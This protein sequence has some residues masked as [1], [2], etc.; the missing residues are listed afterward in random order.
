MAGMTARRPYDWAG[1]LWTWTALDPRSKLLITWLIGSR[2][3]ECAHRLM[4]DLRSR[5]TGR[6][7]LTTAGLRVCRCGRGRVRC[8]CRLRTDPE[9]VPRRRVARTGRH[10]RPT[11]LP[12]ARSANGS[13]ADQRRPGSEPGVDVARRAQEP[14]DAN[15]G[16]EIHEADETASASGR[17][18]MRPTRRSTV[19]TTTSAGCTEPCG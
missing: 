14:D 18:T 12:A 8:G 10:A 2:S 11:V 1:D 19:C 6:V 9:D 16:A 17:S 5:L 4:E 7:Q 13:E 3:P 15:V